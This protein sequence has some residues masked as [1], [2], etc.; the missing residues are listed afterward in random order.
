MPVSEASIMTCR[1]TQSTG[2]QEL[3]ELMERVDS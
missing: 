2:I 3:T 1:K